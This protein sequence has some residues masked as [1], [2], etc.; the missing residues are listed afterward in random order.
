MKQLFLVALC[1]LLLA[2]P[3][4]SFGNSDSVTTI[5]PSP[6]STLVNLIYKDGRLTV[7][8]LTGV[9]TIRIYSIIGNAVAEFQQVDLFDFQRNIDLERKTMYIVR[10]EHAGEIQ[11]YKLVTR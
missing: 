3:Q 7:K 8:G 5:V 9:G 10:I 4:E 6:S 11:T 2:F 1:T